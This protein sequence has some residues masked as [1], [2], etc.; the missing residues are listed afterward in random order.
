MCKIQISLILEIMNI[1]ELIF[2]YLF[3]FKVDR[4]PLYCWQ[5]CTERGKPKRSEEYLSKCHVMHH[6]SRKE[7][8]GIEP[9]DRYSRGWRLKTSQSCRES[10]V[11]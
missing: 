3:V 5:N 9:G 6:E 11:D 1:I 8:S 10:Y 7:W 4:L 2:V